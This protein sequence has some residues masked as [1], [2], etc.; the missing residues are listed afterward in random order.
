[1]SIIFEHVGCFMLSL[2]YMLSLEV[3]YD[4]ANIGEGG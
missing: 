1:M 4:F 3:W 2:I